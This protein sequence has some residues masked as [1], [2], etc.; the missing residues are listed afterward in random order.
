MHTLLLTIK[1]AVAKGVRQPAALS[2]TKAALGERGKRHVRLGLANRLLAL[3]VLIF[4]IGPV[5]AHEEEAARDMADAARTFLAS[6]DAGQRDAAS[7]ALKDEHRVDWHF[8]P[9]ER[10]GLSLARL[11]AAQHHLAMALL[12]SGLSSQGMIKA[13]TI[14]SLEQ[15]LQVIEGPNRRLARNP[16]D[17]YLSVFG[18]PARTGTWGWSFEGHHLSL[19][20]TIVEGHHIAAT[21]SFMG[22]NPAIVPNGPHQG[23]EVLADEQNLGRSLVR[24]FSA[25]QR[26][27]AVIAEKAPRDIV[28]SA[29]RKVSPLEPQGIGWGALSPDQREQLWTL[30]KRYVQRARGE[31]AEA[32]L[33]KIAKAGQDNLSFAWAGGLEPGQ[34]HYYRIQGPTFLIEYD[35]TQN[36]ANHVHA[37]YRDFEEDFGRDLLAEHYHQSH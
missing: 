3:L 12:A 2:P 36:H 9:R 33:A 8:V 17:Y 13:T 20:F 28:T 30:V 23:L 7:F 37:V 26:Q 10:Q 11:T 29:A 19:N 21:P 25:Q 24:S 14:M 22:S 27:A 5:S 18:T 1:A 15:V 31:V 16:G 6:L 35:N 32:D 34:G 4:A